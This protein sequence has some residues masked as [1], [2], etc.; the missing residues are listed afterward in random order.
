MRTRSL[1]LV[2]ALLMLLPIA[3]WAG[4]TGTMSTPVLSCGTVSEVSINILA[5]AGATGAPAGFSLQWVTAAQLANGPDG[6]AGTADDNTWPASESLDLCKGSFSGNAN[7]SR[8]NLAKN[9]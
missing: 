4:K 3:A 1:V 5:C 6:I 9:A 8:Y 2:C 7:G